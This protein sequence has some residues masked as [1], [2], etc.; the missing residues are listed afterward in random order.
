MPN[1]TLATRPDPASAMPASVRRVVHST[2]GFQ[3]FFGLLLWTPVFYEYQKRIGLS[4]PEIFGI[5]SIY[6]IAFCLLELPTG[7]FADR[8]DYRRS[9]FAGAVVLIVANL[10]PVFAGNYSGFL[11]HFLLIAVS[12]SLV[13]GALSAYLYEYLHRSGHGHG[14]QTAEG[15]GRSYS[16]VGKVFCWP[17]MGLLMQWQLS[18]PYW[19]TAIG[20]V[21][22]AVLA[23]RLP[24]LP[25]VDRDPVAAATRP[26]LAESLRNSMRVLRGSRLLMLLILQGVA[27]FTLARIA[28]VNLFQPI[29]NAKHVPLAWHGVVLA[30]MTVFEAFGAYRPGWIR[31]RLSDLN[32]VFVLTVTMAL[33]LALIVAVPALGVVGLLCVFALATGVSYPVQR[34]LV[35]DAIPDSRYRATL[36]SAESIVDRAVCALVALALGAY[37]ARGALDGFLVHT[38]VVTCLSMVVV[39]ALIRRVVAVRPR[40]RARRPPRGR[41]RVR[42]GTL[43]GTHRSVGRDDLRTQA[44]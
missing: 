36:L 20:A 8:F 1:Q 18:S 37:L 33:S 10:L 9:M 22:A 39:G 38:A 16:L 32:T 26:A 12:R 31:R 2:Y 19:L 4:D 5:Q 42:R 21:V 3:L 27:I 24:A 44:E 23:A 40:H 29:L 11:V 15:K 35:G 34:K 28:Q 25:A 41:G 6:Y 7:M 13:S 14:Y 30:A 43:L 17:A